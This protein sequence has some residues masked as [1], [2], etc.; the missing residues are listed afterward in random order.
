ML[1]QQQLLQINGLTTSFRIGDEY[2]P[3]VDHLSLTVHENEVV[4]I[5]GESGCGK[6]AL[7]LSI[8]KL[9]QKENTK[10]EGEILFQG[11]NLVPLSVDEMNRY[12]GKEI[13]M[14]FQD[15]M[16][17]LNPLMRIG[18]QI[19]ES[20]KNHLKMT[21][22]EMKNRAIELL[23]KVGI[24]DPER[25][26]Y[27][28]PHEL[29][30][31]MRQRVVIAI[32]IAC[33]PKL[34]IADEPTTALDVTIQAQILDLLRD[35]QKEMKTGIILITHDLGVVAE[36]ADRVAVMY[37]GQIVEIADVYTLFTN[38][39]HPYTRSLFNSLPSAE[40][41]QERLHVIQGMVPS[42]KNLPRH[43]CRFA[44][45][46]PWIDE[47]AHEKNPQMREVEKDHWVR[48]TCWKHFKFPEEAEVRN[49]AVT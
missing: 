16:T 43:G 29:S 39:L 1:S 20:M 28:Y 44:G 47:S 7:A 30:G 42:L 31:G 41:V 5:V 9:H 18:Q 6:S 25:T 4:A 10:I 13:G 33:E 23:A 2:Y 36:M 19:E 35:M 32:A 26:Y 45:R 38:P 48:C 8:M 34:L 49:Y 22:E 37:A 12:R 14:I 40:H 3:A 15:P 21:K 24:P 27:Q 17:A 46:I 11:K